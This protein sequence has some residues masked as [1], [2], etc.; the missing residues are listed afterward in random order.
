[1]LNEKKIVAKQQ[2]SVRQTKLEGNTS[3]NVIV[4]IL[5]IL[6]F[7]IHKHSQICSYF[8]K[9]K[10]IWKTNEGIVGNVSL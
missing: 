4:F 8:N 2:Y 6:I 5:Y 10:P 7:V 9:S 1:M 3:K